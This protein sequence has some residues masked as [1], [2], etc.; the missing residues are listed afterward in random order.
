MTVAV[1]ADRTGSARP[2][3][4]DATVATIAELE[5]D[6]VV[7]VGDLIEG[8]TDDNSARAEWDEVEALLAP[9]GAPLVPAVGNHDVWDEASQR[10][11]RERRGDPYFAFL[12]EEVLF[13]F[14]DTEDPPVSLP[15]EIEKRAAQM[16]A[17]FE[18]DLEGTQ[19]R[20][21]EA[22]RGRPSGASIPAEV[23]ISLEQERFVQR[24]LTEVPSPRWTVVMM[25]KPAWKN[26]N[27]SYNR[28]EAMLSERPHTVI[29][30]H[31]HYY[32]YD[33][34]DGVEHVIMGTAGGVWLR[35]GPGR[36]DHVLLLRF[37][38]DEGGPAL[39]KVIV[40]TRR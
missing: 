16:K 23:A 34:R 9:L 15:P 32:Q 21:L 38:D 40:P 25:H 11:W 1:L 14:L 18:A 13:L 31:E 24:V 8:Y 2:G 36:I 26:D 19:S 28:I 17:A 7:G 5:P 39:A 29:A 10:L 22:V 3:A 37:S 12:Y 27:A 33:L 4:F 6:L 35:H 30:G 20:I